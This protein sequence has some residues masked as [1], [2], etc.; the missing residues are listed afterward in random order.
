M[1]PVF[2][3][4]H[5]CDLHI[6][7]P[8]YAF[9]YLQRTLQ[10]LTAM[11][12]AIRG[13]ARE[14]QYLVVVIAG[15]FWDTKGLQEHERRLGWW[16]LTQVLRIKN[17][18]IVML[19]GNH[20]YYD[21]QGVTMLQD[22]QEASRVLDHLH[23]ITNNPGVVVLNLGDTKVAF[24]CVP[25][26]QHLT[27]ET[28]GTVLRGLKQ[29]TKADF[30]YAVI[31]ECFAGTSNEIGYPYKSKL[32]LLSAKGIS[33]YL[34]G[35]IHM[36]QSLGSL[37]WYAGSPWQTR[38]SEDHRKGVLLWQP[39]SEPEVLELTGLPRLIETSNQARAKKLA[40]S[41]HS[42]R[43]TGL[44]PLPFNSPNVVHTPRIASKT[45][46]GAVELTEA[47]RRDIEAIRSVTNDDLLDG[48]LDFLKSKGKLDDVDSNYGIEL[49]AKEIK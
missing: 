21:H 41:H 27:T 20:D 42:V 29:Q 30:Y 48:L 19:N 6:G 10:C 16:F 32:E 8:R 47:E 46:T 37:A 36:R 26:Q 13:R 7:G 9:E 5:T 35:D 3:L 39:G 17:V 25:C 45:D 43:Y 11:L 18:H 34:L 31:H 1:K 23:V 2:E 38:F 40:G 44:T 22:F 33:G 28:L 24:L 4:F 15:D 14:V 49:A 12:T